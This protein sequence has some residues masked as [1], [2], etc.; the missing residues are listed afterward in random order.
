MAEFSMWWTTGGAGDGSATYTRS[1]HAMW[2]KVLASCNGL[3]GV[4]PNYLN[5]LAGTVTALNTV[6]INT[7]GAL[8][9]GKIYNNSSAVSV[10]IP[11][12]VGG[13]NT[14]IDRI[15]ARADW[16]AQTVRITRIAGTDAAAPTAP[17]KSSSSGTLYDILLY[18]ALVDTAGTVILTD[19]RMMAQVQ[20]ADIA[21]LA[22]TEAKIAALAVTSGKIGANAVIAGK[23]NTGGV[24]A[25]AQIAND[26]ID[27]QHYVDGSIDTQHIGNL[28]VTLAKMA[29]NSVDSDQY[30]DGSIDTVHIGD[31]QV[32]AA[33]IANRTRKLFVPA[34]NWTG[35]ASI[36]PGFTLEDGAYDTV[37]GSFRVPEDFVSGMT[38]KAIVWPW[39]NSGNMYSRNT[40]NYAAAGEN[41][42]STPH[43]ASVGFA[44]VALTAYLISEVQSLSLASAAIGD[45]VM[46]EFDRDATNA[47]DT[48]SERV[49]LMGW[50]VEYTADS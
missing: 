49:K 17:A 50:I 46:L 15:V 3:E 21:S 29:A 27:S 37:I 39:A 11:S 16:T 33:K 28:Q 9:D 8:V 26:V 5:K 18:Q 14:R 34:F 30:V 32:T 23:I 31:S 7:G 35:V 25:A 2:A 24:S 13:G 4:A 47:L 6:S 12:A 1:D 36:Y 19:E 41:A 43:T 44:A 38:V 10:T 20:A 42:Q 48:L 22:V 40:A 45:Y